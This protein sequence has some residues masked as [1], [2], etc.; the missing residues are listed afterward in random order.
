MSDIICFHNPDE[1]N[2]YLSNWYLSKFTVDGIVFSSVEQYMM[3]NKAIVFNDLDTAQEIM[4]TDDVSVIKKL[5]RSVQGYDDTV[6]SNVRYNIV[7]KGVYHKFT[8]NEVLYSRLI[9]TRGKILAEC[10]VHDR[11][12]G[13]GLSMKDH[14]RYSLSKWRGQN[15]L[16]G[17]LMQV[18]E[19]LISME[20]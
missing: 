3:Y 16:G 15:L 18:R 10:A 12:W 7:L 11:V 1:E 5:G 14:N 17:A 9:A 20:G 6:W 2:G 4:N 19:N 13:I 8:Q